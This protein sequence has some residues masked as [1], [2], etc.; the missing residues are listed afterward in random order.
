M[1]RNQFL[2]AVWPDSQSNSPINKMIKN[3]L[4]HECFTLMSLNL[5]TLF[6][7]SQAARMKLLMRLCISIFLSCEIL[8]FNHRSFIINP[9]ENYCI[10]HQNNYN[11]CV[12]VMGCEWVI[13]WIRSNRYTSLVLLKWE[14]TFASSGMDSWQRVCRFTIFLLILLLM[15]TGLIPVVHCSRRFIKGLL[16]GALISRSGGGGGSEAIPHYYPLPY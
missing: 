4:S 9:V 13:K 16:L 14:C 8:W 15:L 6:W 2:N 1:F 7:F 11:K 5:G 10:N 12:I 3:H